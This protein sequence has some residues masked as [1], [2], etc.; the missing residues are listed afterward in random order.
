VTTNHLGSITES[1]PGAV[2]ASQTF[3][4]TANLEAVAV[5]VDT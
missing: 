1:L 3:T 2:V 4:Q 5:L